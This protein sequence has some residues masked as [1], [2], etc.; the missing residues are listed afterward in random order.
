MPGPGT[1]TRAWRRI[2]R[3]TTGATLR[4]RVV[5]NG[6]P[7]R[8]FY[9]VAFGEHDADYGRRLSRQ[10]RAFTQHQTKLA[11]WRVAAPR[12]WGMY[13]I[14]PHVSL[15]QRVGARIVGREMDVTLGRKKSVDMGRSRWVM[16][17]VTLTC[18]A[19]GSVFD[20]CGRFPC[21]LSIAQ[22]RLKRKQRAR[23]RSDRPDR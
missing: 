16:Y 4:G 5:D 3:L 13:R 9:C 21:H 17:D 23:V 6:T 1:N 11:H 8:P 18:V 15:E 20:A 10:G 14:G 7:Q 12:A 22:Q 2:Q 19:D